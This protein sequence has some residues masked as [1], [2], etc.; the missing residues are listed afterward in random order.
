MDD[1]YDL[2]DYHREVRTGNPLAELW[3]N[4]GLL[5][6]YAFNHLES[7]NCFRKAAEHD[8]QLA[9]AHW[10]IGYAI[11]PYYNKQ[12][13][14]FDEQ[15]LNT[16]VAD[17]YRA[18]QTALRL[19]KNASPVEA[20]LIEALVA[21][22]QTQSPAADLDVWNDDYAD[23]MRRVY[24]RFPDDPD[25]CTL[26]VDALMN[27]TPWALWDL[28]T[29]QP[30]PNANTTEAVEAVERFLDR[31]EEPGEKPHPGLLHV[32]IHLMEMS[33]E[34]ERALRA[35][36]KLRSL[37]PEAAHLR[38]MPTHIDA[39][40]GHYH[41]VVESNRAA[42]IADALFVEREGAMNFQ[43]LGRAHNYHF[44]LYGAMFLGQY[45]AAREAADG[46]V[47]SIPEALLRVES[48]PMAD[49]LEGYVAMN[50]HADIRFGKWQR[51][52]DRPLPED[53][54]L[55]CS[56]TAMLHYAKGLGHAVLGNISAAESERETF[57]EAVTRVPVSRTVFNNT[58]LDILTIASAM[59]DGEVEY[60]KSNFEEAFEKLRHAVVLADE[61]PY[62]EPWGW[63]QPAR[64]ALGALLLEQDRVSEAETVY[65][66]DLGLNNTL[67][68]ACQHPDNVWSLHGLHECL[69]RQTK[70][71]EAAL[72]EPRLKLALA[73]ADVP[74]KSSCLCRL[75]HA[76]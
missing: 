14:R 15:D 53:Q 31:M 24:Q 52:I 44:L 11:G 6:S 58:C 39:Q 21:R 74:I 35:A 30:E 8:P 76:Q 7:A 13:Y 48:P 27:R 67:I 57:K 59:L 23:A 65:R 29:G 34:P 28:N 43:T 26:Y 47:N 9:I 17:C 42:I 70:H 63:M 19:I 33:R 37:A 32:Y 64:H 4:R 60:R 51:L 75:K 20:A 18:S 40:C 55:Y 71:D 22:Y 69:V 56:T 62:D 5:W 61:L 72:I 1:Y 10:G 38:H 50:V 49:W 41:N 45:E 16:T 25:V 73:R 68:R 54:D 36:D 12:W 46:L 66:D 2:G 3:F